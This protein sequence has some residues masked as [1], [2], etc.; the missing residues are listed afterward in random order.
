MPLFHPCPALALAPILHLNWLFL[1]WTLIASL[2]YSTY[3]RVRLN[4]SLISVHFPFLLCVTFTWTP[5]NPQ[6]LI[7]HQRKHFQMLTYR[8]FVSLGLRLWEGQCKGNAAMRGRCGR[9]DL[10]K[11]S[12]EEKEGPGCGGSQHYDELIH[13]PSGTTCSQELTVTVHG[14][15][16]I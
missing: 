1:L 11:W 16:T 5:G 2:G 4:I 9:T 8:H 6:N 10:P 12:W 15:R 3:G 14:Q 13:L 7:K